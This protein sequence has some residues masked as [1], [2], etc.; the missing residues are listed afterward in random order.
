MRAKEFDSIIFDMDGTLWD[1]VD[2]YGQVWTQ[3]FEDLNLQGAVTR[4]QLIECMG[5]TI[6]TI[7]TRLVNNDNHRAEFLKQLEYNEMHM[8]PELG[9]KLYPGVREWIPKLS[10]HY[11]LFMVSN[12]GSDG[13]HNFLR[14]TK[15]EPYFVDTL[16]YCQT[17]LQKNDNIDLLRQ[18]HYLQSPIY[19][20]DTE[21]DCKSAHLAGIP[22]MH[23]EWGFG[24]AANADYRASIM[25]HLARFF[26]S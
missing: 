9:G 7:Y 26:L 19:V 22:M 3:T 6:D 14:F 2:S 15:L 10:E 21:G 24:K 25:E 17:K 5:Q 12:C 11:K 18:C 8:M 23:V 13:L 1:A 4:Q 16:T 20:G